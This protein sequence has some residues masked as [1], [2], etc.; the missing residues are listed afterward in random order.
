[1]CYNQDM[2]HKIHFMQRISTV[3]I[4]LLLVAIC[5]GLPSNAYAESPARAYQPTTKAELIAY[6][7]GRIYQLMEIQ[8]QLRG[9]V[10]P[11]SP[12]PS[13]SV[14]VRI[15]THKATEVEDVTAVL[16]GEVNLIGKTTASAWFEYG[17]D[18]SFLDQKTSK[19]TVKSAYD[20]AVR[21][22]VSKLLPDKRYYFR[23]AAE[24]KSGKVSYGPVYQFRTDELKKK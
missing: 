11:V 14:L 1:M 24:D 9:G 18:E 10:P 7:Y 3:V 4:S 23:V 2:T 15:D 8:Q 19:K 22:N 16:R 20:R 17:T 12:L 5:F 6:L 13:G 21:V